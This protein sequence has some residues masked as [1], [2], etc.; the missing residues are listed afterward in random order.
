MYYEKEVLSKSLWG[1]ALSTVLISGSLT[2]CSDDNSEP[3]VLQQADI[4]VNVPESGFKAV[5]DQLFK[6]EVNS[7]SDEGVTYTWTLTAKHCP[8]AN[9]W[10]TSS[11]VQAHT[12]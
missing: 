2:S 12:N 9:S 6:I 1:I 10:N 8:T 4:T 11:P 5:V 7:V 3:Y